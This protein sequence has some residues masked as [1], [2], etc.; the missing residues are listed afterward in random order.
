MRSGRRFAGA[1]AQA[2]RQA[3]AD[4]A[5][6]AAREVSE[7]LTADLDDRDPDYIRENLPLSG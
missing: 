6:R 4:A 1:L 3:T 5:S 7:R 2:S